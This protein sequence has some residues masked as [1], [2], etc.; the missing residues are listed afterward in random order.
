MSLGEEPG[1]LSEVC[2]RS[3]KPEDFVPVKV[4]LVLLSAL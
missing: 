2:F 3:L 4:S 1:S